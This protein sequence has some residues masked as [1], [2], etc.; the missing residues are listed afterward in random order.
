M[1]PPY[2]RIILVMLII[3]TDMVSMV[4]PILTVNCDCKINQPLISNVILSSQSR[5]CGGCSYIMIFNEGNDY[6][7][8]NYNYDKVITQEFYQNEI[9]IGICNSTQICHNAIHLNS[10]Y[11]L[12]TIIYGLTNNSDQNDQLDNLIYGTHMMNFYSRTKNSPPELNTKKYQTDTIVQNSTYVYTQSVGNDVAVDMIFSDFVNV[13]IYDNDTLITLFSTVSKEIFILLNTTTTQIATLRIN[14]LS[15]STNVSIE[16]LNFYSINQL[17]KKKYSNSFDT[18]GEAS[19]SNGSLVIVFVILS[20]VFLILFI[21]IL[22]AYMK[23]KFSKIDKK[24]R[25]RGHFLECGRI[26]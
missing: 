3:L 13:T 26:I 2:M 18:I 14:S 24:E 21:L 5:I 6:V 15:E 25:M 9:L 17:L 12:K 1:M 23:Y 20:F 10:N 19:T 7:N 4:T 11:S 22:F 8:I 16:R